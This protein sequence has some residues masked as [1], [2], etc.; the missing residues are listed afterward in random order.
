MKDTQNK[1]LENP[2]E[3]RALTEDEMQEVLNKYDRE[4]SNR[5]FAGKTKFIMKCF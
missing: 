2:E 3:I 5:I 1:P 4:S